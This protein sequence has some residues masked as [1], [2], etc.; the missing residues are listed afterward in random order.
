MKTC[1]SLLLLGLLTV[2]TSCKTSHLSKI[3]VHA[4]PVE[5]ELI[6]VGNAEM[7][8]GPSV[9]MDTG[10]MV[11]CGSVVRME[12]SMYYMFYSTWACGKDSLGFYDSWV[13]ESE[14]AVAR[15]RYPDKGFTPLK[16]ILR[17]KRYAGDSLAWDAQMVHN[18][19]IQKFNEKYYL[20]YVGSADPGPQAPGSTGALLSKR[21]RVQQFQQI[22]V[23]EFSSVSELLDGKFIRPAHPLLSPST[24]VKATAIIAPSPAGTL[25]GT[26]NIVVVNPSIVYRPSD[27]K[28][29]LYFKGNWYD[30]TWR[31]VHGVAI[32]DSPVGPFKVLPDII[33]DIRMDD[34]KIASAEDPFVWYSTKE[35]RFFAVL[36]DFTGKITKG[37]ASLALLESDD[38]INWHRSFYA[39]FLKKELVLQNGRVVK[40]HHLERP[41]LLLDKQGMPLVFYGAATIHSPAAYKQTG[42]FNIQLRLARV[43]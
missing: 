27:K 3:R 14:I 21:D 40:L 20:Y 19:H 16:T 13:L 24:R 4:L 39:E 10:K 38:G 12:D 15:S 26:D 8:A 9:L 29:L 34:G 11:W 33:F 6:T 28:Y 35:G 25:A 7:L 37:D 30:P 5:A 17:G 2:F 41:F 23:L 22:G 42:T 18:P 32:G 43:Q 36:K 31:G 1:C